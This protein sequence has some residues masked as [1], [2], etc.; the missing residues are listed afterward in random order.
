MSR[1]IQRVIEQ[2]ACAPDAHGDVFLSKEQRQLASF[3]HIMANAE[4][5]AMQR[6]VWGSSPGAVRA[7]RWHL[8]AVGADWLGRTILGLALGRAHFLATNF[9]RA[10]C[11]RL[12]DERDLLWDGAIAFAVSRGALS[13]RAV[14]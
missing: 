13:L 11:V 6:I 14:G 3:A 8:D 1:A 10:S 9:L 4:F 12:A 2:M 7:Y 5:E